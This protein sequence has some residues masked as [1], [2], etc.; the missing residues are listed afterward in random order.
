MSRNDDFSFIRFLKVVK[1]LYESSTFTQLG[2]TVG[3]A[4]R[5][6]VDTIEEN[7]VAEGLIDDN[8]SVATMENA[9]EALSP[10]SAQQGIL[11]ALAAC[12]S[13]SN[14]DMNLG[15]KKHDKVR[16]G[17]SRDNSASF[18]DQVMSCA[19]GH[20]G[21]DYFSEDD[22]TLGTHTLGEATTCDSLTDDGYESHKGRQSRGRRR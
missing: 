13:R 18:L 9:E 11:S 17:R 6:P 10:A 22:D 14:C 5:K 21:E 8:R 3:T 2:N 12:T 7:S 1:T 19:L 15:D 4:L 16:K 20:E